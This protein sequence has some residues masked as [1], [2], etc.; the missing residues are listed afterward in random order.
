MVRYA[1]AQI[2]R[3]TCVACHRTHVD[4]PKKE[5]EIGDVAGVLSINRPLE[6]DIQRTRTGLRGAFALVAG[7]AVTL[8]ILSLALLP[9]RRS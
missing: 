6:R 9:R 3:E 2:M 5:W 1:R 4:S 7:V 8:L